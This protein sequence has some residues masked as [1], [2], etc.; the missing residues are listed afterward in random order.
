MLL[1]L[2]YPPGIRG[3]HVAA[4]QDTGTGHVPAKD[5]VGMVLVRREP[6]FAGS[7]SAHGSAATVI[8]T[9]P[10]AP[11]TIPRVRSRPAGDWSVCL[12]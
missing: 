6:F 11:V 7:D 12:L 9:G 8:V 4:V 2:P 3:K 1:D 5:G 10:A